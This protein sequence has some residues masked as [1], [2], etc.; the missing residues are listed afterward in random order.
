MFLTFSLDPVLLCNSLGAKA[1]S[2]LSPSPPEAASSR[3]SNSSLS[4]GTMSIKEAVRIAT[5]NNFMGLIARQDLLQRVPALIE[6]IK[7]AGLVLISDGL[8]PASLS[9][10][11]MSQQRKP[12]TQS[13]SVPRMLEGLDGMLSDDG[14]V[15]FK[16]TIEG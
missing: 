15:H 1:T 4:D 12:S 3:V 14:V 7:V 6:A 5:T 8:L 10:H 13:S 9:A 16:N 11:G 2:P